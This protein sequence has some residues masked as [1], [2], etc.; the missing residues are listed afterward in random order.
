LKELPK[1]FEKVIYCESTE[2]QKKLYQEAIEVSR[3]NFTTN[4]EDG[5]NIETRQINNVLMQLRK[6]SDHPLLVR[7]L[8]TDDKLRPMSRDITNVRI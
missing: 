3:S 6:I 7:S 8:Y 5:N 2:Y 1:K 4:S